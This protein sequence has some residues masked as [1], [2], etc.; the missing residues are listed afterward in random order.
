MIRIV[1]QRF[2]GSVATHGAVPS[3][4]SPEALDTNL[5]PPFPVFGLILTLNEAWNQLS[6]SSGDLGSGCSLVLCGR[7]PR[8]GESPDQ[9]QAWWVAPSSR[10]ERALAYRR[11][12]ASVPCRPASSPIG[13]D[14]VTLLLLTYWYT[15]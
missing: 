8:L 6:L 3:R 13:S 2:A 4:F 14:S 10:A 9:V 12:E 11:L 5:N 15:P 7:H 1:G